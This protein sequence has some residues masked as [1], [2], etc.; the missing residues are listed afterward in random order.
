MRFKKVSVSTLNGR[1][2]YYYISLLRKA[3][4]PFK[5]YLPGREPEEGVTFT[6]KSEGAL[7]KGEKV[8]F[9]T[10]TLNETL[11]TIRAFKSV[12][13]YKTVNIGIDPGKATGVALT[14][15]SFPLLLRVFNSVEEV[16]EFVKQILPEFEF[17][18]IKVGDGNQEV[19]IKIIS[20]V[21]KVLRKKDIL[22][23][24][25]ERKTTPKGKATFKKDISA[26][27]KIALREGK[28]QDLR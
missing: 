2:F 7:V 22:M 8:Y 9:E 19:A 16:V 4:I 24:V 3:G 6:T 25:S 23:L 27:V 18:N 20:E 13:K 14:L 5:V 26:A 21:S 17:V 12:T 1:A 10:M 28:V 15:D 11:D